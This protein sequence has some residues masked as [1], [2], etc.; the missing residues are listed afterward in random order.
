MKPNS[1]RAQIRRAGSH[2]VLMFGAAII[3]YPFL[4]M[5]RA[6]LQSTGAIFGA[7]ENA[8]PLWVSAAEN[9]G[10]ALFDTPVLHFML[11]GVLMT[12]AILAAQILTTVTCAFALAKYDFRGRNV[13]F[14]IVLLTLAVPAQA[15]ALPVFLGLAQMNLLD[16]FFA[17]IAPYLTSG[18]AIF[19]FHQFIRGFPDEILLAARLDGMTEGEIALRIIVPSMLPAIAAFAVFSVTFHWNDLYWPMIAIRS[20]DLAPPTLGLLFFRSQAGGDAFGPLMACAT[21][22]T[23]PLILVFLAAQRRFVQGVTMTGVK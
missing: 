22:V 9:Y 15:T 10:R 20:I 5:W 3:F 4:W 14:G 1:A 2:A 16:T 11:N 6:S 13:L 23:A 19:L 8:P 17:M 12:G 7:M 21:L 18:F